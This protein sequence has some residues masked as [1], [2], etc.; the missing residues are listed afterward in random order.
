M[1][2]EFLR[3]FRIINKILL[4]LIIYDNLIDFIHFIIKNILGKVTD[5]YFHKNQI[6]LSYSPNSC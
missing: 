3:L 6:I 5:F 4:R 2:I 1:I